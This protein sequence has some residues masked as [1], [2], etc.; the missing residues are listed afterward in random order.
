M[1]EECEA[2]GGARLETKADLGWELRHCGKLRTLDK[3]LRLWLGN[4]NPAQNKARRTV[5][6]LVQAGHQQ[7]V[8][9]ARSIRWW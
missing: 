9:A 8:H 7:L 2:A 4:G 6:L 3:L 1:G 5:G